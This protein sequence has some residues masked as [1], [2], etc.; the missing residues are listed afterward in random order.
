MNENIKVKAEQERRNTILNSPDEYLQCD[1]SNF[2]ETGLSVQTQALDI[3]Y[4]YICEFDSQYLLTYESKL[5]E[6]D[7]STYY[8]TEGNYHKYEFLLYVDKTGML[9]KISLNNVW[10]K[11]EGQKEFELN[12]TWFEKLKPYITIKKAAIIRLDDKDY[13]V[14][15][16][17][18][19]W[20]N[21]HKS[22]SKYNVQISVNKKREIS[23]F[24]NRS[25]LADEKALDLIKCS[26]K[27]AS[28][29]KGIYNISIAVENI[30]FE[31]AHFLTR[32]ENK[33]FTSKKDF[34][35]VTSIE[36]E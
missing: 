23:I 14:N 4:D 20:L 11:S 24:N 36:K 25:E 28:I 9:K 15:Y 13:F 22:S 2:D 19:L 35:S 16:K 33:I 6:H 18:L 32:T 3:L 5:S 26:N 12:Q 17:Y 10:I 21:V 30:D 31:C 1:L 29:E 8:S 34:Y 7:K 27:I